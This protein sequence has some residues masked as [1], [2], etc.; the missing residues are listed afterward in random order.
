MLAVS[1]KEKGQRIG[2]ME[3]TAD[4][5]GEKRGESVARNTGKNE[6]WPSHKGTRV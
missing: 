6:P 2:L 5:E 3:T 4:I 1:A